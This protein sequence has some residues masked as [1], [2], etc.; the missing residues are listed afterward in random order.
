MTFRFVTPEDVPALLDIYAQYMDTTI[1]FEYV[2]PS[3]GE[4]LRRIEEYTKVFPY[5]V[6]EEDGRI[7]GYAYAH[8][9]FE[10]A[11]YQWDAEMTVY[12][13]KDHRAAGLGKRMYSAILEMLRMQGVKIAYG[14]VTSPNEA[15]DALHLS[16]GFEKL[17]TFPNTGY[18]CSR[19]VGCTWYGKNLGEFE[20]SPR[21]VI[22]LK[23]F[24]SHTLEAILRKYEQ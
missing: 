16:L 24:P 14:L 11:A 10:R 2:L 7:L 12:L 13:D 5:I 3:H 8:Y 22:A 20:A 23:E 21:P 18:K 15:S 4:F 19:W 9:A 17:V 6:A 1:T